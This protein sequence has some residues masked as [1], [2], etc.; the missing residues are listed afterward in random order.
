MRQL[1][2][3]GLQSSLHCLR[4]RYRGGA[5]LLDDRERHARPPVERDVAVCW[6]RIAHHPCQIA[7]AYR[8]VRA[9]NGNCLD[10][11]DVHRQMS[12]LYEDIAV[13]LC[14]ITRRREQDLTPDSLRQ[15][16]DRD[17][18]TPQSAISG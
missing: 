5:G 13:A 2:P 4:N 3:G 18:V 12:G 17:P 1:I 11:G 15:G 9:L 8:P 14:R 16:D 10:V 7:E 6:D